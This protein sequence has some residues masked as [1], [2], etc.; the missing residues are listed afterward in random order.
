[1]WVRPPPAAPTYE[2]DSFSLILSRFFNLKTQ[3]NSN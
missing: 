3:K 1:V 2:I